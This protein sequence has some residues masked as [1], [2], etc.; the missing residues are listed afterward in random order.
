MYKRQVY[1][2]LTWLL[3]GKDSHGSG[4]FSV[5]PIDLPAGVT[6]EVTAVLSVNGEVLKLRKT[7][8]EKWEKHRGSAEAR[9]AGDKRDYFIDDVPRKENEYKRIISDYIDEEHFKLLTSVY[10]FARD[11]HWKD[12]RA[13]LAEVCGLPDDRTLLARCV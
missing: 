11:M 7:L 5:K 3:F 12:R 13:L 1:D 10:A 4:T 6:P 8:R 2:A 9:Y